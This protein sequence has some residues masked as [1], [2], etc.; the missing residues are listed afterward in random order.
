MIDKDGNVVDK[1]GKVMFKKKI[2]DNEDDI[3]WFHI[4]DAISFAMDR[5]LLAIRRSLV[6]FD[7]EGLLIS[8]DLLSLANFASFCHVDYLSCSPTFFA[9][10]C[11]LRIHSWAHLPHGSSHPTSFAAGA[12]LDR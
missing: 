4:R 8:L 2:L 10:T 6:H 7:G 9:R 5:E 1:R 12:T 11:A 3:S